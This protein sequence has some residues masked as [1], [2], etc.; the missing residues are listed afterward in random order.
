LTGGDPVSSR[1]LYGKFVLWKPQCLIVISSNF[2]MRLDTADVAMMRRLRPVGFEISFSDAPGTPADRLLKRDLEDV[3][4]LELPGVMRWCL[5]GLLGYLREGIAEPAE[6]TA[7]REEMAVDLETSLKWLEAALAAEEVVRVTEDERRSGAVLKKDL[8][9]VGVA[10]R[11]Y[12]AWY[13]ETDQ[14]KGSD[15]GLGRFSKV[16][17]RPE[18]GGKP[19]KGKDSNKFPGLRRGPAWRWDVENSAGADAWARRAATSD[20]GSGPGGLH[21]V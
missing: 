3:I 15:Q 6:V 5:A 10:F 16:L 7:K 8:L 11:V 19:E 9:P 12:R 20:S 17:S 2:P 21:L 14:K 13:E 18:A 4:G 1:T